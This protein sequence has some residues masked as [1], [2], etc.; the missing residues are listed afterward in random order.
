MKNNSFKQFISSI[1]QNRIQFIIFLLGITAGLPAALIAGTLQAW[2]TEA[3]LNLYTIG[4]ITLLIAPY[5]LRFLWAPLFDNVHLPGMNRRHSWLYITQIG[6]IITTLI[7]A[8]LNP[9]QTLTCFGMKIPTLML[10]GFFTSIFA[11]SLEIIINAYQTEILPEAERGLG[12]S[13]YVTGWRIG[14]IFSGA[15]ALIMAKEW[16]WQITY[17]IMASLM[18][19]GLIATWFA[20]KTTILEKRAYTFVEAVIH[21]FKDLFS[22]F[23]VLSLTLFFL[24]ILT[25]K[26][27]DALALALNT[28]FLLREM[29][30][31][32]IT[33]GLVNKTV[34]IGAAIL[35]GITAG[36]AMKYIPLYRAL[37]L[38]GLI[39]GAANL[40]YALLAYMGKSLGLLIFTAFAENF[41][42]GMG[43]IA[44]MALIMAICNTQYTA[45]QIALLSSIAYLS[46]PF[47]GPIAA[48]MV[49]AS[50]W[51]TFYI[52]C[53]VVSLPTL[54]FIYWNKPAINRLQPDA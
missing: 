24:L 22:R 37:F 43:N 51:F 21:P 44:L 32:L 12:V 9:L 16:G 39:Q 11:A 20:P 46:R 6:L 41:C 45:S 40:S 52:W 18:G 50:G 49:D 8:Q 2:F 26:A 31:D 33:I 29:G 1:T 7:M 27:S 48:S 53:F 35:G 38:F 17:M 23:N 54:A 13:I 4:A 30:F 42:S 19:I 15:I 47:V 25:Y 34:S 10:V 3:G 28:T 14:G 5:N 36:V